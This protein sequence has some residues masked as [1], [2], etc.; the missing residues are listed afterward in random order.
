[1]PTAIFELSTVIDQLQADLGMT[2]ELL[3][4]ALVINPRTLER[5]RSGETLPQAESRQRLQALIALRDRLHATF[6]SPDAARTWLQ[7]PHRM[8]G[9]LAPIDAVRVGRVDAV[10]RALEALD[11]GIFV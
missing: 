10:E 11:A 5:W 7:H 2:P 8:L 3:A 9:S 1:M 6:T 4:D